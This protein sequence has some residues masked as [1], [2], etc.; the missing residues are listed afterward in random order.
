MTVR[1]AG[2]VVRAPGPGRCPASAASSPMARPGKSA[3][4]GL[5]PRLAARAVDK[6]VLGPAKSS[7]RCKTA[8]GGEF[9]GA[10]GNRRCG[11]VLRGMPS[12]VI[13]NRYT[14]HTVQQRSMRKLY[15]WLA[16]HGTN[17]PCPE[18]P[19]LLMKSSTQSLTE[20]LSSPVCRVSASATGL[21]GARLPS[22][23]QCAE[24][25]G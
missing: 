6:V 9:G 24:Q 12:N 10:L 15:C 7:W 11:R 8:K 16:V 20:Q 2:T 13:G 14:T 18:T 22:V 25:N 21:V 4:R 1:S 5:R 3:G 23:R 19:M 17:A